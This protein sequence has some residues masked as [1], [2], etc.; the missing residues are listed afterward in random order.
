MRAKL[1]KREKI[2]FRVTEEQKVRLEKVAEKQGKKP[3]ELIRDLLLQ[4]LGRQEAA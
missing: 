1:R 4:E 3:G 2:T